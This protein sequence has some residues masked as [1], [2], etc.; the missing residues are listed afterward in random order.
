MYMVIVPGI[1]MNKR[2]DDPIEMGKYI[3]EHLKKDLE[4]K[5]VLYI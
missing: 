5:V 3:T 4:I 2:F 1:S